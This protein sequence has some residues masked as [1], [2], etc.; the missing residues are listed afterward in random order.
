VGARARNITLWAFAVGSLWAALAASAS[1][2]ALDPGFGTG[3]VSVEQLSPFGAKPDSAPAAI[4]V[5]P[6]GKIVVAG[7]AKLNVTSEDPNWGF[8]VERLNPDGTLDQS[9]GNGGVVLTQLGLSSEPYNQSRAQG[10]A[11]ESNGKIVVAGEA[12]DATGWEAVALER[13]NPDGTLD[14]SF[15]SGGKLVLQ[16]GHTPTGGFSD[17]GDVAIQGSAEAGTNKIL[18]SGFASDGS[19]MPSHHTLLMVARLNGDGS[20]DTSF[21]TNGVYSSPT[22]TATEQWPLAVQ[23]DG[24]ILVGAT[25]VPDSDGEDAAVLQLNGDGSADTSFGNGGLLLTH[26][27][28]PASSDVNLN[29]LAIEPATGQILFDG[30]VYLSGNG[31]ELIAARLNA[32]DGS[33]DGS[34]AAGGALIQQ[35]GEAGRSSAAYGLAFQPN[36]KPLLTGIAVVGGTE[37]MF[38]TRLSTAGAFDSSF[39]E[40]GNVFGTF[41]GA[42]T[43]LALAVQNDG[44]VLVAAEGNDGSGNPRFTVMRFIASQPQASPTASPT[45]VAVGEPVTFNANASDADDAI[46]SYEW[47]FDDGTALSGASVGHAFATAGSHSATVTVTDAAGASTSATVTVAVTAAPAPKTS[48]GTPPLIP[49]SSSSGGGA[50]ARPTLAAELGL[51]SSKACLSKRKLTIHVAEHVAQS[52]GT[53]KIKSAEV[54][55]GGL[56]VAHLKGSVLVAH[57]S[58]AGLE[59]GAFKITIKATTTTGKT[60]TASSTY[61]TCASAKAKRK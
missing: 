54:L 33:L 40:A 43:G 18:I 6:D 42:R 53:V 36:D 37:S 17:A 44:K 60:L 13:L 34:F 3:G 45:T 4:A 46:A 27:G 24:N 31:E 20:L 28:L 49:T 22:E 47:R 30:D 50:G 32:A 8:A 1:V 55:L 7:Y 56:V 2:G 21:A 58:L 59:K 41:D 9:F 11:L 52:D 51:P 48:Y 61:H 15:G 57:I 35:L 10:L 19:T 39:G 12:L 25:A 16:L 5:Q 26:L 14:P 29:G 38:L 23:G